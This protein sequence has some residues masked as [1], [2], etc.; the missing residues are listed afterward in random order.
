[1][2]PKPSGLNPTTRRA[3]IFVLSLIAIIALSWGAAR[4]LAQPADQ[5]AARDYLNGVAGRAGSS[6]DRRLAELQGQLQTNPDDWFAYGQLGAAYLQKA[7]ET[8]DPTYYQKAEEALQK[9]LEHEPADYAAITAM[10]ELALARHDFAGALEWG[11]R[12]RSLN[13]DRAHAYGVIVDAQIEL[14]R[15]DDAVQSLQTM[16]DLRPDLSSFSRVS[17]LRE[18]H[19]DVEGAVEAMQ[20][21]VDAGGPHTENTNWTRV[22]LGHLYF[23]SGRLDDAQGQYQ[24]AL[25]IDPAYAPALAGMARV[26][27]AH[28]QYDEAIRLY[29]EAVNRMPLAE[30]V[31]GLGDVYEQTG[32]HAE[33]RKQFDLVRAIEQLYLA[34][35][36]NTDLEMALFAADHPAPNQ[37]MRRV[38]ERARQ[39]QAERPT[40]YAADVLAWVLYQAGHDAEAYEWSQKALAL[41]T[42]DALKFYHAGMIARRIG[43]LSKAREYLERALSLN[44]YFSLKYAAEAQTALKQLPAGN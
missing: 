25:A 33:A 40:T 10:G 32:R 37:D 29:T 16:V 22:Q 5:A 43:D 19:G 15:Y 44:P 4:W 26:N 9:T 42:Q 14:G 12:A 3:L 24:S 34:N 27:A 23:N 31:I 35:G 30:Y 18:L 20:M 1:M 38:V 28:G 6:A 7:R 21:A 11:Q 2:N 41:E 8:G 13:P 36:V 17:Y 39:G